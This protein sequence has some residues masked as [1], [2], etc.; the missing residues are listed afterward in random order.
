MCK[1]PTGGKQ[2][3]E[4][5]RLGSSLQRLA[6]YAAQTSARAGRVNCLCALCDR[7][8]FS[9]YLYT[10]YSANNRLTTTPITIRTATLLLPIP[11]L[12]CT[13]LSLAAVLTCPST[14]R[15]HGTDCSKSMQHVQSHTMVSA[16]VRLHGER[17]ESHGSIS[18]VLGTCARACC[19]T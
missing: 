10:P 13:S 19:L 3:S 1:R 4:T 6:F 12:C 5:T 14:C 17:A 11:L 18:F 2:S 16:C 9:R 7:M 8:N 15:T